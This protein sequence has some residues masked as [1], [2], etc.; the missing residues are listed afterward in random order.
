MS[1][2]MSW[3]DKL[4]EIVFYRV[5]ED[6]D[7]IYLRESN[8]VK[9]ISQLLKEQREICAGTIKNTWGKDYLVVSGTI[10]NCREPKGE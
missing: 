2:Q 3:E 9:L 4:K 6:Q 7:V 1:K 10:I 8:L 5:A